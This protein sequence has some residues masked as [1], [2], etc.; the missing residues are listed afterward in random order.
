MLLQRTI[1]NVGRVISR[2]YERP[3]DRK[4]WRKG[5]RGFIMKWWDQH[6]NP[7]SSDG[8]VNFINMLKLSTLIA[9]LNM[10][11]YQLYDNKLRLEAGE[12]TA[13]DRIYDFTGL[14]IGFRSVTLGKNPKC[15]EEGQQIP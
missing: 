4:K 7:Y 11:V 15:E 14:D 1:K 12:E 2:C 13:A 6:W 9:L 8:K 10:N 3:P 5:E